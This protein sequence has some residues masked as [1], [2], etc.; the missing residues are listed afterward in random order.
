[1]VHRKDGATSGMSDF[2]YEY[3]SAGQRGDGR[4]YGAQVLSAA[5]LAVLPCAL[6]RM[7]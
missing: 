7:F 3:E 5:V 6:A 2:D 1:M 4:F